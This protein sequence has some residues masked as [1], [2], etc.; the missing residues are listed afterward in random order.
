M[1]KDFLKDEVLYL[2]LLCVFSCFSQ[3]MMWIDIVNGLIM[4]DCVSVKKVEDIL[5]LLCKSFGLLLVVLLVLENL[6]ELM[7][8]EWVCF[9]M[10]VQGFQLLDEVE[11][12]VMLEDGG[13]ICVKKQ[14]LVSDEIVVYIEVGK[15]VMKLVFD[16]QQ[17][18]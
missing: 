8:I 18:I 17:C 5:V 7:F 12:K 3:I 2:L 10:V 4:V 16:W 9:G 13:V 11:L 15:V 6:I 1:E 14:D